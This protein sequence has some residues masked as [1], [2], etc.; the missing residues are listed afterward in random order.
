MIPKAPARPANRTGALALVALSIALAL[1]CTRNSPPTGDP[2]APVVVAANDSVGPWLGIDPTDIA[3]RATSAL[4]A[5][6]R[7]SPAQGDR[8]PAPNAWA[9]RLEILFVRALPPP[10]E[11]GLPS[12]DVAV[13][14]D[15]ARRSGDRL[16]AEGR[17]QVELPP[18]DPVGRQ[19]RFRRALDAALADASGQVA[20]QLQASDRTDEELIADLGS[21]EAWRRDFAMRALAD[22]KCVAAIPSLVAR[23]RDDDR[24]LQLRA[25][26]ALVEIGDPSA[27]AALVETTP[28]R[29][30][31]FVVQVIFALG[32][33]G[34]PDAEA[35]LFTASTGHPD[36]SVRAAAAE[37]LGTLESRR[38]SPAK[39]AR[40]HRSA[41]QRP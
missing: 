23:L 35:Y 9:P 31:G 22:R 8:P 3:T 2:M 36:P 7:L 15:L 32:E 39:E 29:D 21:S 33:L 17:G 5:T 41:T 6:G 11:G 37:A 16:R 18:G 40:A 34:G 26:G 38:A 24:E 14:L 19:E 13:R 28:Q 20:A 27:S 30:P 1:G 25:V 12:A 10:A 4:A